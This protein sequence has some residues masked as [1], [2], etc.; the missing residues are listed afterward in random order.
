MTLSK[1][2]KAWPEPKESNLGMR[3]VI[4][5]PLLLVHAGSGA[6]EK[7]LD[8]TATMSRE[9]EVEL[10]NATLTSLRT[11]YNWKELAKAL[12]DHHVVF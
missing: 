2:A 12:K 6:L 11:K 7:W 3:T 9:Q 10:L 1:L 8:E 5:G 4:L